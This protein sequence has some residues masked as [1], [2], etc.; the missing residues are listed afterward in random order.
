VIIRN[1]AS[2]LRFFAYLAGRPMTPAL[3]GQAEAASILK[4]RYP[5]LLL[6][7]YWRKSGYTYNFLKKS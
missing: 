4:L 3:A 6:T 1:D 2:C 5:F 7:P